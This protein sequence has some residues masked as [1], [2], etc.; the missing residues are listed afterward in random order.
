MPYTLSADALCGT[1][2]V[3][4]SDSYCDQTVCLAA[5]LPSTPQRFCTVRDLPLLLLGPHREQLI[6]RNRSDV[7]LIDR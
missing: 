1:G 5:V 3:L 4:L 7:D 2:T 6:C